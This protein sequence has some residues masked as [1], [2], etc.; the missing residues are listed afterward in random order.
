MADHT[1]NMT[2]GN[3][4][5][6]LVVFA[7]PLMM[8][9]VFQQLYT[10]V[11]TAIV[12]KTLGVHALAALGGADSF[13][14]LM[15]SAIQGLAQGFAI[16][17]AQEFGAGRTDRLRKVTGNSILLAL[18]SALILTIVGEL[19]S[20]PVLTLMHTPD[21]II[22][23]TTLYIRILFAGTPIVM[24]YN[25]LAAILRSLGDSRTPLYA[26]IIASVTNI[27]LDTLFVVVYH[28]GIA[29]AAI[30]TVIA[31]LISCIFCYRAIRR[32]RVL[33]FIRSD[34]SF[35]AA[36]DKKLMYLGLPISLQ[37]M[38]I[39][40][41]S[42]IVQYVVNGYGVTFIAGFAATYKLYGVLEIA[43]LGFAYALTTYM[44]QNLGAKN[45]KRITSG[46]KAGLILAVIT[47]AAI[48]GIMFI[49][50]KPFIGL[51]LSGSPEEV[52]AAMNIAWEF[53]VILISFL[54]ILYLVH[55]IRHTVEGLGNSFMPMISGIVE[56]GLRVFSCLVL[57]IYI[58]AA[59]VF[60]GEIFAWTG[61]AIVLFIA[62]A[63]IYIKLNHQQTDLL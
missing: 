2:T 10:V 13:N 34:F 9:N 44:G 23:M 55:T 3:P 15:L 48:T 36:I 1:K 14:W 27:I 28:F 40:V 57:P 46:L 11:D 58:G 38:I 19:V 31:Q 33:S 53:M 35:D 42:M 41:G 52:N 54:P 30:A 24:T 63:Y 12:G 51:F 8:G 7:L 60:W 49:L 21:A 4:F 47:S 20:K 56:F 16:L 59:G 17:I 61:A 22:D 5:K 45:L 62:Y 50:G 26:I 37:N 29:G 43:G 39:F 18:I 6:L 32:I 25:M